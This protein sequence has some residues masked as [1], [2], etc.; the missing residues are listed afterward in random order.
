MN[1]LWTLLPPLAVIP[2]IVFFGE[3]YRN[4]RE[5][6]III[7]GL[8][9]LLLNNLL[10]LSVV[11][12]EP[13]LSGSFPMFAQIGLRLSAEPLGVLF[14]LLASFLWVVTTVYSI[15]YMRGHNEKNQTRFY[16]CFALALAAVM[17]AAYADNLLTLF[18]AYEVLTLSTF[19][20]VTHS[21]TD[22]ARRAGRVYLGILMVGSIALLMP[23]MIW[24]WTLTGTLDFTPG[25]IVGDV[26]P[27][28]LLILLSLCLFGIGKAAVMPFHR[29]LP[30]AMVAPTP[31][32]ALLHAVAVVKTGVFS[33]LKIVVYIFGID[34]LTSSGVVTWLMVFPALTIVVA[35]LIAMSKNN[36]KA[37]LAYSTISQLSYIVLAALL[38]SSVSIVGGGLHIVT[39]AFAKITL[40]FC[41]G[42]ILVTTHKSD[43]SEFD[44][45]ARRMP[46]TMAA[47]FISSLGIIGLPAVGGF[48]SKI[49][50]ARGTLA[51]GE[52]WIL[53][54]LM[55]STIMSTAYLIPISMRAFF[56]PVATQTEQG[57]AGPD[58][59]HQDGRGE[60]PST[61]LWAIALTASASVL[62]FFYPQPIIDLLQSIRW[63][64]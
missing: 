47:F 36:L 50:I 54:V 43:I 17:G 38:A 12:G 18:V 55:F 46:V 44:G 52:F 2:F 25:G 28:V 48:W 4:A 6:A 34:T 53:A 21:G 60:A 35:S 61:C 3:R 19:P 23:A 33:L 20:L 62:L 5:A 31:V 9:L 51:A 13:A 32:S 29:W 24:I 59:R 22:Q 26:S 58:Y 39:H 11:N 7:A 42:A 10:Y 8:V 1:P 64:L 49:M 57:H 41:A 40:F 15:G 45:L 16:V 27:G 14:G 37:R 30:A 63:R 56:R